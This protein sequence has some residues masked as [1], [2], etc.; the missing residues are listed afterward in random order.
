MGI[1]FPILYAMFRIHHRVVETSLATETQ[2]HGEKL[3]TNY[4]KRLTVPRNSCI[5]LINGMHGL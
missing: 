5:T 3:A 4:T 2:S 1:A